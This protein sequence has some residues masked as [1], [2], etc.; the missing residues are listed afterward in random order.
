MILH[1]LADR[2]QLGWPAPSWL[3][4]VALLVNRRFHG[5]SSPTRR[6]LGALL[7]A[8]AILT[9]WRLSRW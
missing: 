9:T 6:T 7:A 3:L 2:S 1:L 5:R 4:D 8:G